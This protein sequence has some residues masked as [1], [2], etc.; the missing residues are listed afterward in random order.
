MAKKDTRI[1]LFI[2]IAI[3]FI[4][5]IL[6]FLHRYHL[7]T[8]DEAVFLGMGKWIFSGGEI[9]IWENIRPLGLPFLLGLVWLIG[10]DYIMSSGFLILFFTIGVVVFTY[11]LSERLFGQRVAIIASIITYITPILFYHSN[12]IF[13]GIPAL[14]FCLAAIYFFTKKRFILAAILCFTAFFFRYPAGLIF[15][16]VQ[17][18]LFIDYYYKP[19]INGIL[20]NF[21]K[22][23]WPFLKFNITF[24]ILMIFFFI[25]NKLV[26][27]SYIEPILMASEHQSTFV[28]NV[29]GLDYFIFYPV[30]L[31]TSNLLFLFAL[32]IHIRKRKILY[33]L[34]PF[35][36]FFAYFQ[37]I[38]H[39]TERFLILLIPYL[40][41]LSAVG[42]VRFMDIP[43]K[44]IYNI[45]FT[46]FILAAI[47]YVA[48]FG[49]YKTLDRFPHEKP[50]FVDS[51]HKFFENID[52][53]G[54]I[55]TSDPVPAAY[56]D[57]KY[58]HFYASPA[59]GLML[60]KETEVDAYIYSPEAFPWDDPQSEIEKEKMI[61][62]IREKGDLVY[63]GTVYRQPREIYI[64]R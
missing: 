60:L 63:N 61:D 54:T 57:H 56:T 18:L 36:V 35:I 14:F 28:G 11:L 39:K 29:Y 16:V 62:Y 22:N 4:V 52:F 7:V 1:L 30:A 33:A 6:F 13:T 9:G 58:L 50:E 10:L 38:P 59:V 26:H 51:Y 55:F 64:R 49:S 21:K 37:I 20:D 34:I 44:R 43:K 31:I 23:V 46:V 15:V 42:I 24:A 19:S 25:L 12:R 47:S 17:I 48:F 41:I 8:W 3:I 40:A 5:K 53:E 2:L 32:Y 45:A 27:G